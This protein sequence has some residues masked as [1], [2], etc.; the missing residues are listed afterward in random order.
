MLDL[1]VIPIKDLR[2]HQESQKC[3]C[4]PKVERVAKDSRL[5]VHNSAD[6]RELVEQHGVN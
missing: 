2:E 4:L 5:I 6:G 3:W 1:H